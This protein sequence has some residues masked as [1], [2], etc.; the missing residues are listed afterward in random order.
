MVDQI[1]DLVEKLWFKFKFRLVKLAY[2]QK[3]SRTRR[4][5][6]SIILIT[7]VLLLDIL[8]L[9]TDFLFIHSQAI[10]LLVFIL[11]VA[12][13]SWYGGL[14]PG[15][16]ATVF[17]SIINYLLLRTDLPFYPETDDLLIT[18]VYII[19]G[20]FISVIS[21][22]R[23]EVELQKDEFIALIAHEIKNP[24]SVIKGFAGLLHQS[25][26]KGYSKVFRYTEEIDFQSDKLLE[27]I[28][29]LLDVTRIEVGKFIY[30]DE[31]FDFD[32]LVKG[33]V[34]NQGIINSKREITLSANSKRIIKGDGYRI[35]QVITNLLTNAIKYSPEGS[36]I[37][38]YVKGIKNGVVLTVR[39]HGIG[40]PKSEH[41]SVF[42]QFYR[43]RGA[44]RG[45]AEGLGLGLFISSQIIKHHRGK[46]GVKSN[47]VQ[48]ST[49]YIEIPINY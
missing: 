39:D 7:L 49:F 5:G 13:S 10:V 22:A 44:E 42:N 23:Y 28:N 19:V 14:G 4:Y 12:A 47:G 33:V 6:F 32:S 29:D 8:F 43:S 25:S 31:L 11:V 40:I 26:K 3:R 35:G 37:R 18:F 41:R 30:K 2:L 36:P 9:N 17:I 27:L 15:I 48:G 16:L 46:L 34:S 24:L 38:V 21:E 1:G 20:F 45:R